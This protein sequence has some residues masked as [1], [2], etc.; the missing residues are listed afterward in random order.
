[1]VLGDTDSVALV[2]A[3]GVIAVVGLQVYV[4]PAGRPAAVRIEVC[5][6]HILVSLDV[7]VTVDAIVNIIDEVALHPVTLSVTVT[8]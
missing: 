8:E 4:P 3:A 1:M 5:P 2:P 7:N 6:T